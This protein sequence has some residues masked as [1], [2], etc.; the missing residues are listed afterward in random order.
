MNNLNSITYP[1]VA[2]SEDT[3][4]EHPQVEIIVYGGIEVGPKTKTPL[5]VL[6]MRLVMLILLFITILSA[7][8]FVFDFST[9]KL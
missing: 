8:E 7:V 5:C 6:G 1:G 4:D 9:S 3:R 2:V